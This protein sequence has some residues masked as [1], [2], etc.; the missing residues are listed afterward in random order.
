LFKDIVFSKITLDFLHNSP[1]EGCNCS[2][3]LSRVTLRKPSVIGFIYLVLATYRQHYTTTNEVYD[4]RAS[5][6]DKQTKP[7]PFLLSG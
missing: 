4:E 1:V 2:V 7:N 3:S 5:E 6:T